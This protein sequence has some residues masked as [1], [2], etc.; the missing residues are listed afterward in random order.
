MVGSEWD[1]RTTYYPLPLPTTRYPL[2][3]AEAGVRVVEA[4]VEDGVDVR[5]GGEVVELDFTPFYDVAEMLYEGAWVA[6][7]Y[8]AIEQ[9]MRERPEEVHPV[10]RAI[11]GSPPVRRT[12]RLPET[13]KSVAPVRATTEPCFSASILATPAA[14]SAL[15]RLSTGAKC[16]QLLR[17]T[18]GFWP[19]SFPFVDKPA[20][21]LR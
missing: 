17:Q 16:R 4:P 8:A 1:V 2:L 12:T 19:S 20:R 13:T 6:E 11:I 9:M 15:A 7:R 10:T 5:L 18:M 3:T 14:S 21:F